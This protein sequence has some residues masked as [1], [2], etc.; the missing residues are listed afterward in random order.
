MDSVTR[1]ILLSEGKEIGRT[2][3]MFGGKFRY[4]RPWKLVRVLFVRF[5]QFTGFRGS[6]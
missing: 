6:K 3:M 2:R 1:N 5:N 4:K